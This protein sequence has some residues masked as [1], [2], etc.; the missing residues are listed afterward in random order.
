MSEVYRAI[1]RNAR[2]SPRKARLSAGLIRGKRVEDAINIL[3]F[4]HRRGSF[5]LR[6]VLESAVANAANLGGADPLDLLVVDARVDQSTTIKRFRPAPK[7]RAHSIYKRCS[8]ITVAV[9]A[10]EPEKA[11]A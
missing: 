7:G 1:Q 8:H 2:I 6:K 3:R 9:A 5:M 10:A 4:E 11:K